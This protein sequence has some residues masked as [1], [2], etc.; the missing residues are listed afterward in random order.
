MASTEAQK[1]QCPVCHKADQVKKLETAYNE[2]MERFAPPP[3]PVKKVPIM[4]YMATSMI[5]VGFFI[6]FTIVLVGSGS[7][8]QSFNYLE[9][10]FVIGTLTSIIIALGLSYYA[11]TI[12]VRGDQ[13]ASKLY[14]A[15]DRA[16]ENWQRL[17][18][19]ARDNIVFD[20]QSASAVSDAELASLMLVEEKQEQQIAQQATSAAH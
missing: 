12:V 9:L 20:P 14:P 17:R 16:I 2:G 11:F 18:Y 15:W 8:G 6:F 13:E 10:A 1:P 5:L 7:F 3:L 19:C 4:R